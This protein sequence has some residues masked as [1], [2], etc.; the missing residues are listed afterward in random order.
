MKRNVKKITSLLF[1]FT[2]LFSSFSTFASAAPSNSS[3]ILDNSSGI[4]SPAGISNI[5]PYDLAQ[6]ALANT[7]NFGY[8]NDTVPSSTVHE[9]AQIFVGPGSTVKLESGGFW[10]Y[11]KDGLRRVRTGAKYLIAY[12]ANFE[13]FSQTGYNGFHQTS[14][15]HVNVAN[16]D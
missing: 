4:I 9:A 8:L 2:L 5:S 12:Q 10:Y 11:S 3:I 1:G 7:G 16:I 13:K 14:N 6:L 15:Y